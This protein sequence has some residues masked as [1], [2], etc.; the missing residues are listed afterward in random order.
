MPIV[1]VVSGLLPFQSAEAQDPIFGPPPPPNSG[2]ATAPVGGISNTSVLA[3]TG[4]PVNSSDITNS[5]VIPEPSINTNGSDMTNATFPDGGLANGTLANGTLANDTFAGG[6]LPGGEFG[7]GTLPNASITDFGG[8]DQLGGADAGGLGGADA[9]GGEGAAG[10]DQFGGGLNETESETPPPPTPPPI[11]TILSNNTG[12]STNPNVAVSGSDVFVAW[13]DTTGGNREILLISSLDGQNFTTVRNVTQTAGDSISPRIAVSGSNVY[14]VWQDTSNSTGGGQIMFVKSSDS[15][16]TFTAAKSLSNNT[17]DSTN[18][19]VAVSGGNVYVVWEQVDTNSTS[20]ASNSEAMFAKSSDSG[21]TFTAA[22]SL[23]NSPGDSTNPN[24]AVSGGNVYVVWED[25]SV[26]GSEIVLVRSANNGV[27]FTPS[28]NISNS[29]GESFGPRIAIS[30]SNVYVVWVD[31]SLG[32]STQSEIMLMRS[33]N[34][35]A[36]FASAENL[37]NSPGESTDPRIAVSEDY[38]YVVWEDATS[39]PENSDIEFVRS[40]DSGTTFTGAR[41]LSNNNGI[42]FDPRISVS[43]SN[44]YV[45]WEDTTTTATSAAE[46]EAAGSSDIFLARSTNNGATFGRVQNLSNS[47]VES[48]DPYIVA[49]RSKL[50][51]LW[52]DDNQGN[53]E[54]IFTDKTR[55]IASPEEA[56][57]EAGVGAGLDEFG[58]GEFGA[59]P[60]DQGLT[61]GFGAAPTDQGLTGGFGAAPTDQGL[62]GGLGAGT[63][64]PSLQ[65]GGGIPPS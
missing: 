42:S 21:A 12:D 13:E 49:S 56:T 30:E 33:T 59:A 23:S 14:L 48:F 63:T 41:N 26:G 10:A 38:V 35:G 25:D 64:D 45:V 24:V 43:G 55:N 50:F 8:G 20:G 2:P 36:N 34:S 61:G 7:D 27:N 3:P 5:S 46:G 57:G 29:P 4:F 19:N 22:K 11:T 17:G 31:Y 18:P 16:A 39:D 65:T 6:A 28:R 44:V 62:T 60:T 51:V 1:Q 40:A 37:S 15:G 58:A 53:A 54:V 52:S 32:N 47:P 9:L